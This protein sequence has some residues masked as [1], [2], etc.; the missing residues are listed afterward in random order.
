MRSLVHDFRFALRTLRHRRAFALVAIGTIA[1]GI[2][3]TTSIYSIVDG[4]LLRP[5]PWREPER[6]VQVSQIFPKWKGDRVLDRMWNRIPLG[7][8][9]FELLRDRNT[10]FDAVGIWG[11]Y[12]ATLSGFGAPEQV[13][14]TLASASLLGVLGERTIRGRGFNTSEDAFG[15]PS[16]ALISYEAWQRWFS[17]RDD[18]VGKFLS[19]DA[20]SYEIVGVLPAGLRLEQGEDF[21]LLRAGELHFLREILHV[22]LRRRAEHGA[23]PAW[24]SPVGPSTRRTAARMS[25]AVESTGGRLWYGSG[26]Q[27]MC[28]PASRSCISARL[29]RFRQRSFFSK[30]TRSKRHP[31]VESPSR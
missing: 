8:D 4:V 26:D 20:V 1:L 3:A 6:L 10:V 22:L 27:P 28:D 31:R 13:R 16:I 14:V 17:G 30:V 9:E 12:D 11:N 2:G 23:A 15:G 5:L 25:N 29:P 19:L 18:A 21:G 7:V 24:S